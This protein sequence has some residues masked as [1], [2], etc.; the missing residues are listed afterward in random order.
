MSVYWWLAA[1]ALVIGS[2]RA[3]MMGAALVE[4]WTGREVRPE[5]GIGWSDQLYSLLDFGIAMGIGLPP[6]FLMPDADVLVTV[7]FWFAGI[8]I[9]GMVAQAVCG[10]KTA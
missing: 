1:I 2:A 8:T 7:S 3:Q 4:R 5:P 10:R 9:G 6:I